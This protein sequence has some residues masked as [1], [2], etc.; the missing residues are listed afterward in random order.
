ML[1]IRET[2][3]V[4][5]KRNQQAVLISN[6]NYANVLSIIFF[7]TL[8]NLKIVLYERTPIQELNFDYGNIFKKIKNLIIKFLILIFYRFSDK[9]V[10]NS[11]DRVLIYL[12]IKKKLKPSIQ[13]ILTKLY[14]TE[15]EIL[16]Y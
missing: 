4:C 7:R 11:K 1:K 12:F 8:N 15:E 16:K 14:L 10:T 13:K 9:I 5:L 6:I 3:K 2:I